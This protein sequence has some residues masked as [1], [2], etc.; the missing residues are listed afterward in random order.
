LD[1]HLVEVHRKEFPGFIVG[2][3]STARVDPPAIQDLVGDDRVDFVCNIPREAIWTGEAIELVHRHG[4][5]W[6]GVGD[7]FSAA[8]DKEPTRE[9]VRREYEFIERI[10][11]Q[12]SAVTHFERLWDRAYRLH[13]RSKAPVDVVDKI[14]GRQQFAREEVD[15]ITARLA[16]LR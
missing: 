2:V 10:F 1:A 16:S 4:K 11:R 3:V 9:F 8:G 12:H 13:R 5:A 7:L 15:R 14:R 6:G